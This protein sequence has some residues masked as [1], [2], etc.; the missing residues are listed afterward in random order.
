METIIRKCKKHGETEF[1]FYSSKVFI[2]KECAKARRR[3]KY[4]KSPK[5]DKDYFK[6]WKEKNKDKLYSLHKKWVAKKRLKKNLVFEQFYLNHNDY[7]KSIKH[8]FDLSLSKAQIKTIFKCKDLLLKLTNDDIFNMIAEHKLKKL[9]PYILWSQS[10]MAKFR[11]RKEISKFGEY[12]NCNKT[13]KSAIKKMAVDDTIKKL[14]D[15]AI[16]FNTKKI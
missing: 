6:K 8:I 13:L 4:K 12:K 10:R 9:K 5:Y 3:E 1:Y 16:E 2:C 15:K 14:K 11:F 7:F